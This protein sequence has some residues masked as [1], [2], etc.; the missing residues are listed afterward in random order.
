LFRF[1]SFRPPNSN[2]KESAATKE[3][4]NGCVVCSDFVF[5]AKTSKMIANK[6]EEEQ[7]EEE[8]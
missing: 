5:G 7:E 8:S 3:E 1:V 4:A 2:H 6:D